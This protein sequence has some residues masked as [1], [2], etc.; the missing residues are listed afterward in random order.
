MAN[1]T[2]ELIKRLLCTGHSASSRRRHGPC[3][4]TPQSRDLLLAGLFPLSLC[5][6][7]S[8]LCKLSR[9]PVISGLHFGLQVT[10][11]GYTCRVCLRGLG[12]ALALPDCWNSP[13]PQ[14]IPA[15]GSWDHGQG[16][17]Y[18]TRPA[19]SGQGPVKMQITAVSPFRLVEL[20]LLFGD[21]SQARPSP[22]SWWPW[23]PWG[24]RR[25]S[26]HRC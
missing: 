21:C 1:Q 18:Q 10:R 5:S 16:P 7:V 13:S 8:A 26:I 2:I 11:R 23:S 25:S 20:C 4:R 6:P 9:S 24:Q 12:T 22:L 3:P 15:P 14:G 19:V 17:V